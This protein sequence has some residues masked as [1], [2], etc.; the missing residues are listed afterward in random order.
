MTSAD[1]L[2]GSGS[3]SSGVQS[4]IKAILAE[5]ASVLGARTSASTPAGAV[6]RIQGRDRYAV[7]ALIARRVAARPD[8]GGTVLIASGT[9][10]TDAVSA[11]PLASHAGL[12]VLLAGP[13]GL[14]AG[15][16]SAL[17]AMKA[18]KVV[19]VGGP[20]S[21]PAAAVAQANS[22]VGKQNVTRVWGANRYST[23]SAVAKYG[24]DKLGL[25]WQGA[26]I[27]SGSVFSDS[28]V[29]GVL[30]GK[31]GSVL[32]LTDGRS[33]SPDTAYALRKRRVSLRSADY[34]GGT[35]TISRNVRS[36]VRAILR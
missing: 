23:S 20:A 31:K 34:I 3:V 5:N 25:K 12:P 27:A 18:K 28:I 16:L 6:N 32:L 13:R 19:I 33:L 35:G 30:K 10:F 11:S 24:V 29:G 4:A 15:E 7:A 36:Q 2:G 1:I 21:V 26:G 9:G 8:F 22:V 14:T 17:R